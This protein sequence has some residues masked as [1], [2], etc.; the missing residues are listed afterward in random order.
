MSNSEELKA[1]IE[2]WRKTIDVQ[3]HF[4]DIE[5]R[6]RNIAITLLAAVMGAASVVLREGH[7]GLACLIFVAGLIAWFAFFLMDYVWYHPLLKGS[8]NHGVALEKLLKEQIPTLPDG[9]TKAIGDA[10]PFPVP[11]K[12]YWFRLAGREIHSSD[13]M[14]TFYSLF[15]IPLILGTVLS[16]AMVIIGVGKERA[17]PGETSNIIIQETPQVPSPIRQPTA[18]SDSPTAQSTSEQAPDSSST[19]R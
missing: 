12:W 16:F 18:P 15:A 19:R 13:K 7:F 8:V 14:R 4:N 5:L 3:Q 17:E 10:S 2:I 11:D 6:I 1:L 9:L